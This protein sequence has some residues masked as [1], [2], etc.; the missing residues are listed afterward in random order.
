MVDVNGDRQAPQRLYDRVKDAPNV[1]SVGEPQLNDKKTVAIVFVTPK[2]APQDEE[3]EQL[4]HR[5]RDDVVPLP[6]E[7]ATRSP[8]SP[9]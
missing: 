6:R 7:A 8:T 1:A 2:S 5:L 4:V 3:L 9:A